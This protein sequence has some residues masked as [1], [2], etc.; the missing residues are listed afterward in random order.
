MTYTARV[1]IADIAK[2]RLHN[3]HLLDEL[4]S[5]QDVVQSLGAIQAQDFVG[6]KWA[7]GLR[8]KTTDEAVTKAFNDGKI[9]RTHMLRPTW[10]FVTPADI[11][12]MQSLT[13][14]R[15]HAQSKYY[16]KKLGMDEATIKKANKILAKVLR[17]G[18]Q[19]TKPDIAKLFASTGLQD[20]TGLRFSYILMSAELEALICSGAMQ[21]KQHTYALVEDRAPQTI[22]LSREKAL[23]ELTR[24]F[25]T[26]HGPAQIIDFSWWSSLT[27]ADI[28]QGIALAK[29]K[30]IEVEGKTYY[31]AKTAPT[32]IPS[33]IAHL[34][35]NYDE[36][37]I[38][39]KDRSA[40]SNLKI[41][42]LPSYADLSYHILSIDGQL[43][44]GWKRAITAKQC[45]VQL[46]A[47]VQLTP[48]QQKA[49]TAAV[50]RLSQFTSLPVV[51]V[52]S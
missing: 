15:V 49:L 17:G 24:R 10:H 46:N 34:L 36:Y 23:A 37:F 47:F 1:T 39:Y 16:Y 44:G 6:A 48:A 3:Q 41:S 19:L 50:D 40:F 31:V 9:L 28:K 32:T 20:I 22:S 18:N 42:R 43:A 7:I 4:S 26:S 30:S 14:P 38:G 33:P 45:T 13:A 52:S 11:R 21:G 2:Q 51:V 27:V 8:C 29:L 12:W 25:F 35:P 5:P